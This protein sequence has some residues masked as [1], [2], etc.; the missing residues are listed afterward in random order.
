MRPAT[1]LH[2]GPPAHPL[3]GV[4]HPPQG[5]ADRDLGV[6]VCA[7]IGR[8][9]MKSHRALRQLAIRLA[10]SGFHALRF[11]YR[12]C[13]DSSGEPER[14]D[15]ADWAGDV[16][17]AAENLKDRAGLA[18][19]A[20]VG[21][22]LGGTLALLGAAGR[23]D[24][25]ALMLWEPILDGPAYLQEMAEVHA[26]WRRARGIE[27]GEGG[28]AQRELLGFPVGDRLRASLQSLTLPLERRLARRALVMRDHESPAD[29]AVI[30]A[31][32]KLGTSVDRRVTASER[33]W[34]DD[35]DAERAIVPAGILETAVS[36]LS[37]GAE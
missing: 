31:L 21:L 23:R 25:D 8:E 17:H 14:M 26:Q 12:G 24:V 28:D 16:G 13:G 3:F 1:P 18:K 29:T 6:V 27:G 7:P 35:D 22:R 33:I 9:Y 30:D 36:W 34:L 37:D 11:D 10:R 4:Y 5:A 2:F 15:L 20:V 32:K 19:V